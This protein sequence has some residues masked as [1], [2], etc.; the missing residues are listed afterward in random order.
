MLL[1]Q[2]LAN[3]SR[4][5]CTT[6]ELRLGKPEVTMQ[7]RLKFCLIIIIHIRFSNA[8]ALHVCGSNKH[9][10][11]FKVILRIYISKW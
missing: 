2:F 1:R 9:I 4:F 5:L 6:G 10:R 7:M 3:Y 8:P 11:L